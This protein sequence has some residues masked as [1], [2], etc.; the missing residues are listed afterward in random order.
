[1][2]TSVVCDGQVSDNL[3]QEPSIASD[4]FQIGLSFNFDLGTT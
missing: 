4:G 1:M 3:K 2:R